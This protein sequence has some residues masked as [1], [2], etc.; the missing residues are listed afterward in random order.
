MGARVMSKNK[1]L[2]K[3]IAPCVERIGSC[4][5]SENPF[6]Q[7]VCF[8]QLKKIGSK[9]FCSNHSLKLLVLNEVETA[10]NGS[11]SCNDKASCNNYKK[12]M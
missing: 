11:F 4:A 7:D 5:V 3:I 8:M 9:S 2:N 12:Q 6:L 10:E 1:S